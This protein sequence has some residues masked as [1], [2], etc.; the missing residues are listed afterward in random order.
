MT[1]DGSHWPH[2]LLF[3]RPPQ[4]GRIVG[5]VESIRKRASKRSEREQHCV[6]PHLLN[7]ISGPE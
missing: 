2:G 1:S 4:S 5:I 7:Q 6:E 3:E